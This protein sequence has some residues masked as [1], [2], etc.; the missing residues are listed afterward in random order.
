MSDPRLDR[1][2]LLVW[3]LAG[4]GSV[5]MHLG[6]VVLALEYMRDDDFA[7]GSP[8]IEIDIELVAPR[9]EPIA[10]P[11]GPSV[12]PSMSS[13][14][15]IEQT[16][17]VEPTL[18]LRAVPTVTE[19][20]ERIVIPVEAPEKDRSEVSITP[21]IPSVESVATEATAPPTSEVIPVSARSLT[22]AQGTGESPERVRATWHKDLIAHFNRRKRYPSNRSLQGAQ[23]LVG[24]SIDETGH[25]LSSRIVQGSGDI[26]FDAAALAMIER[27]DPVPKPP[28][29]VVQEG[30][31]FTLPVIFRAKRGN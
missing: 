9:L 28:F 15:F 8:A 16:A 2:S 14:R 1:L 17:V 5:A 20:P 18:L 27:S 13:P 4:L 3:A 10:L 19:D 31:S 25:V 11:P 30:L 12:D 6:F 24:F 22:P 21:T 26:S 23:L 29:L 7:V